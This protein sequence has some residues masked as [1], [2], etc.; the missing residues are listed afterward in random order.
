MRF[1]MLHLDP[2]DCKAFA[3]APRP[4]AVLRVH[5]SIVSEAETRVYR[6]DPSIFCLDDLHGNAGNLEA[7]TRFGNTFPDAQE[8]AHSVFSA[9]SA[10]G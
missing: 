7:Y 6:R 4:A 8:Q 10:E 2:P 9:L 3:A 5:Q 1:L